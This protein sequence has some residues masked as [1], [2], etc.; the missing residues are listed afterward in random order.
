MPIEQGVRKVSGELAEFLGLADRGT[1]EAG[2]AADVVVFDLD[3]LDP[4]PLRRVTDLPGGSDRLVADAPSG[5][6]HVLVNGAPVRVDGRDV[7]GELGELPGH[8]VDRR[9]VAPVS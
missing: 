5:L 2:R 6:R 1:L 3:A 4:G 9:T 7:R 8:L